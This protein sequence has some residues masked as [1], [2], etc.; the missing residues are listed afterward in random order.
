VL[1]INDV[2]AGNGGNGAEPRTLPIGWYSIL[3]YIY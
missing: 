3:A 1:L 2:M